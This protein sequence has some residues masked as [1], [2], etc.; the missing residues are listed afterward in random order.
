MGGGI[1]VTTNAKSHGDGAESDLIEIETFEPRKRLLA[2][3][4][5][6]GLVE[7]VTRAPKVNP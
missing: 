3:V 4:V 7:I 5:Q 2:R 6:P 1:T